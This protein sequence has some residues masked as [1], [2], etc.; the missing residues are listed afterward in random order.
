MVGSPVIIL[1]INNPFLFLK[2]I[3]SEVLV[4]L[5]NCFW[6]KCVNRISMVWFLN[7]VVIRKRS[8]ELFT[9]GYVCRCKSNDEES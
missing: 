7:K 5:I 2:T 6:L 9:I 4:L 8:L 1:V 3:L